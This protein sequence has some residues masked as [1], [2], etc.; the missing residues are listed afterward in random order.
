MICY[1]LPMTYENGEIRPVSSF[2]PDVQELF[3]DF[4]DDYNVLRRGW[5]LVGSEEK[6]FV[7]GIPRV[8]PEARVEFS[9]GPSGYRVRLIAENKSSVEIDMQR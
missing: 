2:G 3:R 8:L 4:A 9:Q 1:N 7:C 6:P 5:R